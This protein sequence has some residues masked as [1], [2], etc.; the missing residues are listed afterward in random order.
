MRPYCVVVCALLAST[1]CLIPETALAGEIREPWLVWG[2]L[3]TLPDAEGFAGVFAG[4]SGEALVVAGGAN[5]PD[6]R[7][8]DGGTKAWYDS[9]FVLPSPEA[10]WLQSGRLPRPLAY[11]VSVTLPDGILCIGGA[12]AE[13]HYADV[14][15]LRWDGAAIETVSMPPLPGP[16]AYACGALLNDTV[17]V[18]GGRAEP[19]S[20]A[21]LHSFWALDLKSAQP[22]WR[23]LEP[24]PG[25][26]RMLAVAGA[27]EGSF[28]LCG[29]TDLVPDEKGEAQRHYLTDAY[30]YTP[31]K[32]WA[33][34]ADMPISS[35]AAPTPAWAVGPGHL[36]VFG[37]DDGAHV[38]E[39]LR[40]DH[41]GFLREVMAYHTV[42]DA[43]A[44]VDALP[45]DP[46]LAKWPAV[47]TVAVPW[48]DRIVLPTG[49]ARPGI[50]T[51]HVISATLAP[52]QSGFK[53]L[54]YVAIG[55]YFAI[56]LLMGFF[57]AGRG[58]TTDDFFV[59]G[60]RIPWWAAGVS[61]FGT[62]L[63]AITFMAAP[64]KTYATNWNY[65]LNNFGIVFV[66][67]I[68]VL[69]FLPFFRRLEVTTAYE[70]LE[71]RFDVVTR[72]FGSVAFI[73]MQ[74]GR[75]G[76][77]L[78]L[79][80]IALAAVT[81][82]N[83]YTCILLMGVVATFYTVLGGIE[84]VI[85]TD[86]LQVIVLAGGAL[87]ALAMAIAD[88]GGFSAAYT[89]AQ[90]NNK[91]EPFLWTWDYTAP[92]AW[93]VM[94]GWV[95][96]LIPYASDQAVVQRYLTTKDERGAARSI[97]TN[98]VL[99]FPVG[100]VFFS[101][102]T[103]LYVFYRSNPANLNPALQTDAILPWFVA[104]QLP[105]GLSGIVIAALFAASMSSLDSSINS[106]ATAITTDFLRRF[107][108]GGKEATWLWV[109]RVLTLF[110]GAFGTGTAIYMAIQNSASM[111]DQWLKIL[112]LFG[113]GLAGLFVLG[114]FTR[115]ANA[116]GAA[117]GVVVS[118][119]FMYWI[120]SRTQINF[121]TWGTIGIATCFLVGYVVSLLTGGSRKPLEGLTY[122]SLKPRQ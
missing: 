4:V 97:W 15:R 85:W 106:V 22:A 19:A 61:I 74:V 115:R 78:L 5:F 121:F 112:G 81:G 20:P 79:P 43:W 91:I 83:V 3:P 52:R 77:V 54:D 68:I 73:A 62:Q 1:A 14:F 80:S 26:P 84:A 102:G 25:A 8:W 27:Q 18:A 109:A 116:F 44:V 104:R 71:K 107:I 21:T 86:V 24:W 45:R 88:A 55:G 13:R 57:F 31:A 95:G 37:G 111:W 96:Q 42:T 12:D 90:A 98:V 82:I 34:I 23:E 50:R 65:F 105:A 11:G 33:R 72:L 75:M 6:G 17:Y 35:V 16:V 108:R 69:Y 66:A 49:E 100:F 10:S 28:F 89:L 60:R 51:P 117:V 119:I 46:T 36:I 101:L 67:P 41:P 29:G 9:V 58:Q 39:D 118:A 87:I 48:R 92:A 76:I 38:N 113:G 47:T 120:Q 53:T 70:Y 56:L 114:V 63:S 93:I 59:A 32:G 64:A 40:E 110:L 30:R 94:I 7:P 2:D 122:H 99:S 103:A